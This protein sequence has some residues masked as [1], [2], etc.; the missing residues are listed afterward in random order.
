M[1]NS[2]FE[3]LHAEKKK[4]KSKLI[5]EQIMLSIPTVESNKKE[6]IEVNSSKYLLILEGQLSNRLTIKFKFDSTKI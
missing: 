6:T 1:S 4:R 3:W 5:K 2:N